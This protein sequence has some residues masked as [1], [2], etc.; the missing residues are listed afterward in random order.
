MTAYL[1]FKSGNGVVLLEVDEV[2]PS[3]GEQEAGLGQRARDH[4]AD[5]MIATRSGFEDAVR[6]AIHFSV[7]AFLSAAEALDNPP[8]EIEVAF[9]LKGTGEVGNLAIAKVAGECNY[10]VRMV[11]RTAKTDFSDSRGME[12][13]GA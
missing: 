11:W 9:G 5:A 13:R 1:Q 12:E 8:A 2:Y 6:H 4:V 10:Q 3:S 7:P